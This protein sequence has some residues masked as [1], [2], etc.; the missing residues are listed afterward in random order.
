MSA[1]GRLYLS[2]QWLINEQRYKPCVGYLYFFAI[3]VGWLVAGVLPAAVIIY[4]FNFN[5]L[6][7]FIFGNI[8]VYLAG[9]LYTSRSFK[10]LFAKEVIR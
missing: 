10:T 3:E 9:Y 8:G 5:E 1:K 4:L 7:I 2:G 6:V